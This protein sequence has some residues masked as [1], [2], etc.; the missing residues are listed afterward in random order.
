MLRTITQLVALGLVPGTASADVLR[1]NLNVS[2]P[3]NGSSWNDAFDSL[4]D[5]LAVATAADEIWVARGSYVPDTPAGRDATFLIKDGVEVYGGFRGNENNR[6]ERDPDSNITELNGAGTI[7]TI[8]TIETG[9]G[10]GTILDGFTVTKGLADG[11]S[12]EQRTGAGIYGRDATPTISNVIVELCEAE[13]GGSAIYLRGAS[14]NFATL[15]DS[16]IR[17]NLD[18]SAVRT[19]VPLVIDDCVFV[20]NETTAL[21]L[22]G[23]NI[24]SVT[25][26]QFSRNNSD[27]SIACVVVSLDSSV[28]FSEFDDCEFILNDGHLSG[29]I[30]YLGRGDHEIRNTVMRSNAAILV[31]QS[32]GAVV[33]NLEQPTDSVTIENSLLIGNDG[34][35]QGG[36]ITKLGQESLIITGSTIVGNTSGAPT[37]GGINSQSD[38]LSMRNT[39]IYDNFTTTNSIEERTQV[40][41]PIGITATADRCIIDHLGFGAGSNISAVNSSLANPEFVDAD[42]PDNIY[43][44]IDDNVRLM[45]GSPAI[46]AGNSLYVGPFVTAD[47]YNQP[48]FRDDTGTPDTGVADGTGIVVDIGAA[49]FQ[50]T[51]PQDCLA[52]VNNDGMLTPTDFTAWINAFNNN[53]P[54]CD[55]NNDGSCTPTDYTAWIANFN[56]GC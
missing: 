49:E 21:E 16:R 1:V 5:A 11:T 24:H 37:S 36:A 34:A 30:Y 17:E 3:G 32:A 26:T 28:S 44:N 25:D 29:G 38:G 13:L 35:G 14:G 45:P 18:D 54:E 10:S 51:T 41:V 46:D 9:A 55:Q 56:A 7:Y 52:D 22:W 27:P 53:L 15:A 6:S 43:G 42:G 50:G 47:I 2:S 12:I 19:H 40:F 33:T 4:T 23:D 31:A 48:R 8:V 39:I 20:D